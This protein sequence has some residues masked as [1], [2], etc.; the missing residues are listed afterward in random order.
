[1]ADEEVPNGAV[2]LLPVDGVRVDLRLHDAERF[3]Y[4]PEI[5]VYV[6]K[7]APPHLGFGRHDHV[8]SGQ[9]A[10]AFHR[11]TVDHAHDL[12]F[13]YATVIIHGSERHTLGVAPVF[14]SLGI[15]DPEL[16]R[17]LHLAVYLGALF[18]HELEVERDD[19]LL[20]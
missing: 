11:L 16:V 15:V 17:L 14:G 20:G 13:R 10:G 19:A 5:V 7:L 1:M 4:S 9:L 12:V 6:V 2:V 3:L 18:F 8:A